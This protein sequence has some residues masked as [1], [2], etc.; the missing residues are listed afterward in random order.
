[1]YSRR[2]L[3][4][5]R[6][7]TAAPQK[8]CNAGQ[9]GR[10]ADVAGTGVLDHLGSRSCPQTSVLVRLCWQFELENRPSVDAWRHPNPT[11]VILDD[12]MADGKSDS[13]PTLLGRE[14][15]VENSLEVRWVIQNVM[16]QR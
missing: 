9:T 2:L 3:G 5:K 4:P 1:M 15:R 8:V 12:R 16:D 13:H 6:R 14:K 7:F 11:V 10:P